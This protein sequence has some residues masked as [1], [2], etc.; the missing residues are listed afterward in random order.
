MT[1]VLSFFK[2]RKIILSVGVLLFSI[3]SLFAQDLD[4][5]KIVYEP[6]GKGDY[7]FY[8][9]NGIAKDTHMVLIFDQEMSGWKSD[10]ILPFQMTIRAGKVRLFKLSRV[11]RGAEDEV[12]DFK[13]KTHFFKGVGNPVITVVE[14]TIPGEDGQEVKFKG[15]T[16][17]D[18]ET[19][20]ESEFDAYYAVNF[21]CTYIRAMRSGTVEMVKSSTGDGKP[22][23][24]KVA[25][26][27]GTIGTYKGILR[28]TLKAYENQDIE[29][30]QII[31]VAGFRFEDN[32]YFDFSVSYMK[33]EV[34]TAKDVQEWSS[35]KYVKP[36]FRTAKKKK[37][38][39]KPNTTYIAV[40]PADIRTQEMTKAEK[41]KLK[42][43]K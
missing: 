33:V 27:D 16:A 19:K 5:I 13:F 22:G 35:T 31:G 1:K 30:G 20:L 3:S 2:Y 14:Y 18:D 4:D 34:D 8:A 40:Y 37:I 9:V 23:F 21:Y 28:G 41:K 36:L 24:I 26:K 25:H 32:L 29:A 11:G 7:I 39:L 10:A 6:E 15:S 38:E 43:S 42:K 17:L 12:P